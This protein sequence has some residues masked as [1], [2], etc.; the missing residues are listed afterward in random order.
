[1]PKVSH[2][3]KDNIAN[4]N[5]TWGI[6]V[7]EGSNGR[8]NIDGGGNRAQG[9]L[10]PIDPF[11]LQ[12]LQCFTIRCDGGDVPPDL[13]PPDT[14]ILEAPPDPSTTDSATFHFTGSD[15]AGP[16]RS[17]AGST[18]G[19][20]APCTSPARRT[21]CRRR[22]A[23]LRGA[24]RRHLR[25]RRPDAGDLHL[26]DHRRRRARRRRRSTPGRT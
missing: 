17:S 14:L 5:G 18:A 16:S 13:I 4:D 2:I 24:R 23:H 6:Y 12:P 22:R 3:I 7:S 25:Q 1:M 10:G 20:F 26:D 15:N 8:F 11:T 9:N 21:A 19:A